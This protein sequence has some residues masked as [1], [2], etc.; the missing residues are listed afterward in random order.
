MKIRDIVEQG[1]GDNDEVG[2]AATKA[3]QRAVVSANGNMNKRFNNK[4]SNANAELN[5]ANNAAQRNQTRDIKR[6]PTGQPN[7]AA[8]DAMRTD[9]YN[10]R[11]IKQQ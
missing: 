4:M 2:P 9:M 3:S 6:I 7:R 8:Y 10:A 1:Y 5:N 11:G